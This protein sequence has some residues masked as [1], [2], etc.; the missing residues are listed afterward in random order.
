LSAHWIDLTQVCFSGGLSTALLKK[1]EACI[2]DKSDDLAS[3]QALVLESETFEKHMLD[4]GFLSAGQQ[5]LSVFN[6]D[7]DAHFAR[8]IRRR[9]LVQ[10]PFSIFKV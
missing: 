4:I 9:L 10:V 7:I 6:A 2:P 1:M 3:Y 5:T 8:K